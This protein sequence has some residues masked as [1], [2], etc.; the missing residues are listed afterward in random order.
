MFASAAS[1]RSARNHP[2]LHQLLRRPYRH[3]RYAF[4]GS[5]APR[6]EGA[7]YVPCILPLVVK[8]T[9]TEAEREAEAADRR[10]NRQSG[11][12]LWSRDTPFGTDGYFIPE[13]YDFSSTSFHIL[14]TEGIRGRDTVAR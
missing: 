1:F 3:Y 6:K 11:H 5:R 10:I 7:L 2:R 14:T 8:A 12:G 13:G 9:P 4:P